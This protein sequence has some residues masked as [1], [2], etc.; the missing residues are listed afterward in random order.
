[1]FCPSPTASP[2]STDD[3]ADDGAAAAAAPGNID[4]IDND[5][6]CHGPI[7]HQ[8]FINQDH[9]IKFNPSPTSSPHA[10]FGEA[11]DGDAAVAPGD[12]DGNEHSFVCHGEDHHQL[13]PLTYSLSLESLDDN[14]DSDAVSGLLCLTGGSN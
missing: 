3:E 7:T 4:G 11:D 8:K 10:N 6:D 5:I 12:N 14:H 1:M 13:F 2:Y 9:D